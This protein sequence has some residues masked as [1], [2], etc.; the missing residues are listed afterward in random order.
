MKVERLGVWDMRCP[1]KINPSADD[2]SLK[3][4]FRKDFA[5]LMQCAGARSFI[6]QRF[7]FFV[8]L[9]TEKW[10][11]IYIAANPSSCHCSQKLRPHCHQWIHGHSSIF[12]STMEKNCFW[13]FLSF[14]S[15]ISRGISRDHLPYF[16]RFF[17]WFLVQDKKKTFY[18][19]NWPFIHGLRLEQE[20]THRRADVAACGH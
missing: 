16:V 3:F 8:L 6:D 4:A 17:M 12:P 19:F 2:A 11:N 7:H 1:N 13:S 20:V 9:M 15:I 18:L 5:T 14:D 10:P